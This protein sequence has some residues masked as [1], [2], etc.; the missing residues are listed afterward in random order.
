MVYHLVVV[1]ILIEPSLK[2]ILDE[3]NKTIYDGNHV[4]I[5]PDL[6]D[7]VNPRYIIA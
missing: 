2:F 5:D 1:I 4:S 3:V 6:K 7:G